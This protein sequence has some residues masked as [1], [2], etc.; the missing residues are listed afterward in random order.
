L[1][2]KNEEN[3][4]IK[5]AAK[6]KRKEEGIEKAIKTRE[7]KSIAKKQALRNMTPEERLKYRKREALEKRE[8]ALKKR[9]RKMGG[10]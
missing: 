8:K 1:N 3:E 6:I 4:I 9:K 7:E 5:A 2:V 10:D